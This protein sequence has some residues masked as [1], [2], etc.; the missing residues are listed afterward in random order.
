M[1]F[2]EIKNVNTKSGVINNTENKFL[3]FRYEMS[4]N[5]KQ[6]FKNLFCKI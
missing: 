1:W 6:D 5:I 3:Q 4:E 2:P